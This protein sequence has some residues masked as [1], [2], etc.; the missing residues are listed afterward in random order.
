MERAA[1]MTDSGTPVRPG[2]EEFEHFYQR[3]FKVVAALAYVLSGSRALA[4]DLTQ[5]AFMAAYRRWDRVGRYDQPGAWVR[6]A[7]A[8]RAVSAWRRTLAQAS[9]VSRLAAISETGDDPQLNAEATELWQAVRSLP[10]RQAQSVALHYLEGLSLSEIGAV[11]GCSAGTVKT[12]LAR[13]RQQLQ[14]ELDTT[15]QE[16]SHDH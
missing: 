9:L 8:N 1:L 11:L 13:A 5:D 14:R 6:R 10:K 2:I 3:E 15:Q 16:V 4:E 12:H 7:V